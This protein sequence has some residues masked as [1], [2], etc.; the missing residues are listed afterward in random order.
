MAETNCQTCGERVL[1]EPIMVGS[2]D[3]GRQLYRHCERCLDA[4]TEAEVVRKRAERHAELK[5]MVRRTI[6][7][8]LLP[9]EL[10]PLGTDTE[11]PEFYGEM[12]KVLRKWRPGPHGNWIGLIGPSGQC[13]TRCLGLLAANLIMTGN[14]VTWTSAMRLHADTAVGLRSRDR[15]VQRL[16]EEHLGECMTSGWL[17]LDDLGN[18][19]WC[20]AFESRLFMILDYRKNN[21]LPM[22]YSSN[23]HPTGL[24]ACITSVNSAALIGR[25]I[26]R[27]DL[28]DFTRQE[29]LL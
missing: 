17:I 20:P 21:R 25:L 24:H 19:E 1:Y 3:L 2:V 26:D 29:V 12:W 7:P 6:P 14:R 18:N 13:K 8:E 22:A 11:H 10:D 27:A 16:A 28:F 5:D 23:I 4:A 9:K 15:N